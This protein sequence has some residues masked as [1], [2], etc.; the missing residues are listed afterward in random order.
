MTLAGQARLFEMAQWHFAAIEKALLGERDLLL[1]IVGDEASTAAA[2]APV[3]LFAEVARF[4]A[5]IQDTFAGG[6]EEA[7]AL[8]ATRL[9]ESCKLALS[10]AG[11]WGATNLHDWD[12]FP[13]KATH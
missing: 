10:A 1:P 7:E 2:D 11:T 12:A 9:R 5:L 13:V 6:G 4:S 3:W 8:A